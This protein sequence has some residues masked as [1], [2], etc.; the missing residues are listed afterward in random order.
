MRVDNLKKV[1]SDVIE[2]LPDCYENGV[3]DDSRPRCTRNFPKTIQIELAAHIERGLLV[4]GASNAYTLSLPPL[5]PTTPRPLPAPSLSAC[6]KC[7][8]KI[9]TSTMRLWCGKAIAFVRTVLGRSKSCNISSKASVLMHRNDECF[10][11]TPCGLRRKSAAG[12][13]VT[14]VCYVLVSAA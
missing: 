3:R 8:D 14:H 10:G 6:A 13:Y 1:I 9:G 12:R 11:A 5:N 2:I 7:A 4:E